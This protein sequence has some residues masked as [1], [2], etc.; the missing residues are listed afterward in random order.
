MTGDDAVMRIRP[1]RLLAVAAAL[2]VLALPVAGRAVAHTTAVDRGVIQSIDASQIVLR[3]LDGSTVSFDLLPGTRVIL[4]RERASL[5][6]IGPGLVA[7]VVADRRGR[8][9]LIRAFGTPATPAA[10]TERG[11]VT[12][13]TK[14]SIV[15]ALPGG[16]TRAVS[17][18]RGTRFLLLGRP[19]KRT[20]VRPGV[21]VAVT[22]VV[23][24]PAL[25]VNVL[26]RAGA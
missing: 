22:R 5:A 6:E 9:V 7:E 17:V 8:A 11:A 25:V 13:I 14:T 10:T 4:N 23:D 15:Y 16:V 21:I 19:A 2:L 18:D 20:V 24:G 3:A 26:K 1:L 12:S